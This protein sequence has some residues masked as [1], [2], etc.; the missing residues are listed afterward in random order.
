MPLI[1]IRRNPEMINDGLLKSIIESLPRRAAQA[2]SCAEGG[3]LK[4]EDIMIEADDFGPF[5]TNAKDIHVRVIAHDYPSRR[6][7]LDEI[8]T[9]ISMDI[10]AELQLT[11]ASWYVWVLLMPTSYGSD[12]EN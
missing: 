9:W 4:P 6:A 3:V 8:R 2:L 5:D 10:F 12:T 7:N 11:P 1:Q